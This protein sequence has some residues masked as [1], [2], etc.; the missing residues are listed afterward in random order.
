MWMN[1]LYYA[2]IINL[3]VIKQF[4]VAVCVCVCVCVCARARALFWHK[5]EEVT[6]HVVWYANDKIVILF[7]QRRVTRN[8]K[9][10]LV[11]M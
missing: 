7:R 1:P 6:E 2:F 5:K 4:Y 3:E 8:I 11:Y 10:G 9:T